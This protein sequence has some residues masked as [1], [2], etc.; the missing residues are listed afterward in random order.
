MVI[1]ATRHRLGHSNKG[2]GRER[3]GSYRIGSGLEHLHDI[4]RLTGLMSTK[5]IMCPHCCGPKSAAKKA[6]TKRARPPGGCAERP[7]KKK[8]RSTRGSC[9]TLISCTAPDIRNRD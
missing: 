2:P 5:R 7:A 3:C 8:P 9:H 1:T 6:K 4:A